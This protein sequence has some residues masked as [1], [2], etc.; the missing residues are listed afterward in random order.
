MRQGAKDV[1]VCMSFSHVCYCFLGHPN[2]QAVKNFKQTYI[3]NIITTMLV[4]QLK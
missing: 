4:Y 2:Y 1:I 3:D